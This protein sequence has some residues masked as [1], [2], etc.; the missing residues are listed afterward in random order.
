MRTNETVQLLIGDITKKEN[1]WMISIDETE[2]K[3][4]KT[5]S[6]IRKVPVHTTLISLGFI[7]YVKTIKSKVFDRVFPELTKKG[8]D[9]Q[10]RFH[11]IIMRSFTINRYL[12]KT[13]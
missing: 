2:G 12:G 8:M 6:S 4:L 7:D 1:V 10:Q 3:S 13:S 5:T 9:A 11:N